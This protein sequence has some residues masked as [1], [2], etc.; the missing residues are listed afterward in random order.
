[1]PLSLLPATR[2]ATRPPDVIAGVPLHVAVG[3]VTIVTGAIRMYEA[4]SIVMVA[5]MYTAPGLTLALGVLLGL[6]A[7]ALLVGGLRTRDGERI[8]ARVAIGV[9]VVYAL[10]AWVVSITGLTTRPGFATL[11]LVAAT[12]RVAMTLEPPRPRRAG[13]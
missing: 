13:A 2:R 9:H 11:L 5:A 7:F 10:V 1:M 3:W 4:G 6:L 12:V 8:G